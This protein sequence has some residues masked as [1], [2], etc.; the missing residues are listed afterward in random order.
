MSAAQSIALR[1]RG[2]TAIIARRAVKR[3]KFTSRNQQQAIADQTGCEN[4]AL[5]LYAAAAR[6]LRT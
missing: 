6:F 4:R 3:K 5:R 2:I 1:I